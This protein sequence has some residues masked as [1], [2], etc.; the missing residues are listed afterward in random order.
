MIYMA[1]DFADEKF[2]KEDSN[3]YDIIIIGAGLAGLTCAYTILNKVGLD[4]LIIEANGKYFLKNRRRL[5]DE[6]LR[7]LLF[8][9]FTIHPKSDEVGGRI[10]SKKF[11]TS[12]HANSSQKHV[13]NLL[14]SLHIKIMER[15]HKE[16]KNRILYAREKP[17]KILPKFYGAEVHNFFQRVT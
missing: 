9:F 2:V 14:N 5:Y 3:D 15:T 6:I 12:Y 16:R 7:R 17:L 8:F 13:T 10:L 1:A 11:C 4:I